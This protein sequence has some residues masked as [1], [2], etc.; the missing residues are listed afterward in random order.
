MRVYENITVKESEFDWDL[1]NIDRS[2]FF[3][4]KTIEYVQNRRFM[5]KL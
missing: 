5:E 2:P 4:Q 1:L 3:L